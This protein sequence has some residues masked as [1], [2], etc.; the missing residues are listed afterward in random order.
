MVAYKMSVPASE[1]EMRMRTRLRSTAATT[2]TKVTWQRQDGQRLTLDLNS[3]KA[4]AVDGWL[5]CNLSVATDQ[6]GTQLLQFIFFL[7]RPKE[8]DHARASGTINTNTTGGAQIAAVWGPDLQRVLWD[9]V[10]DF[11]EAAVYQ[12]GTQ[13]A[14]QKLTIQGFHATPDNIHAEVLA[15]DL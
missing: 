4:K 10:L 6:T 1:L 2:A 7:G 14:G 5:V 8:A 11:L 9:C 15:G 13:Q 12:A 3:V